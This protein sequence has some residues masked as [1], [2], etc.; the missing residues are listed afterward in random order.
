MSKVYANKMV[1]Y[2]LFPF[3][4]EAFIHFSSLHRLIEKRKNIYILLLPSS[5]DSEISSMHIW[6]Y[7]RDSCNCLRIQT[8]WH[9]KHRHIGQFLCDNII[10]GIVDINC[11]PMSKSCVIFCSFSFIMFLTVCIYSNSTVEWT[12]KQKNSFKNIWH[13]QANNEIQTNN[14]VIVI[15]VA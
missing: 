5:K 3:S 7:T 6:Q 4:L 15:F 11:S 1:S 14:W 13:L 8:D 10:W 2:F 12:F 9:S